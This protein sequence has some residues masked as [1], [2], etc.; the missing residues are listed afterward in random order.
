MT[1]EENKKRIKAE[2][3]NAIRK[4]YQPK[5]THRYSEFIQEDGNYAEQRDSE[6]RRIMEKMEEELLKIKL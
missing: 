4:L 5:S 1:K 6:V 2:A 3:F